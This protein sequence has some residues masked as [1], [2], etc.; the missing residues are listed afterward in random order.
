M[1]SSG[2]NKLM[3]KS[4]GAEEKQRIAQVQTSGA[5]NFQEFALLVL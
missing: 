2:D 5:Q 3:E 4:L 1:L